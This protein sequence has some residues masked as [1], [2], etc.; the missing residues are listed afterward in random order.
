MKDISIL[1]WIYKNCGKR[2]KEGFI[3]ILLNAW[4]AMCV[5]LFALLSKTVMDNAQDGN[6]DDLVKN[7]VFL[8]LLIASQ[9]ISRV[10]SSYIE[11]VS[12]GK[13]EIHLKTNIFSSIVHGV[14]ADSAERHSGDLMTRLTAD[15]TTVSNTYVHIAPALTGYAVRIFS[16]AAALFALD[17]RFA[18]IFIICGL[19]V[20]ITAILFRKK[21]KNLHKRV[22]E[23][24][25]R[26]RSFMQEMLENLFA[27]KVF[28]IEEKVINRSAKQ[29]KKFY[30]EKVRKQSFSILASIGFSIAFAAGFLAAVAYGSYGVLKGT[31]TFGTVV[32]IIQL[33]NQLQS[34]VVG[35]TGILPSFYSMTASAQRLIE[36]SSVKKEFNG[37]FNEVDYKSF[38]R[39]Y[40]ENISFGY[41]DENV[42]RNASFSIKK[43]DF[44]GIKGPSGA[45][46]STIFKLITGI[47][48]PDNGRIY[49]E[50][51][52]GNVLCKE[53]RNLYSVVPQGNMLFSGT[54][55]ENITMLRP[56]A[57]E[58]EIEKAIVDSC[59]EF[60]YDLENG[61][62]FVLG[63]DGAGISEGQAQRLAITRALLGKGKI[64]LM[65]ESTSALD[66][67]SEAAL[68]EKLSLR[69]DLTIL[70]ITH[71]ESVLE[72]C[73]RII[74]VS[75][76][77]ITEN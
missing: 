45:G 20:I 11:A 43:G 4:S 73:N 22:Q 55:R 54:V 76:G 31:M 56:D 9:M 17:K 47:Y 75:D 5:T 44:V 63:E 14:Y 15:V 36:I 62:D 64:L 7:V 13:A 29:Q 58:E 48:T 10:F 34:P 70:F 57:T 71:R 69:K 65:D 21:L 1:K 24:D 23:R 50:T 66:N 68:L 49:I 12:Q 77:K 33:V 41:G 46:K 51:N 40:A 60:A 37:N 16:G 18:F 38:E 72:K 74:T 67:D 32:A 25:S 3:L 2:R 52:K 8:F 59:A 6:H 42:I 35:F 53:A 30:R 19:L 28:G 26:V 61:L 27:I 39:I